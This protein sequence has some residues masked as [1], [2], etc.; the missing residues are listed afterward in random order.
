MFDLICSIAV[1]CS[2]L[3]V[4]VG[5]NATIPCG[6]ALQSAVDWWYQRTATDGTRQI[7]IGGEIVV[8]LRSR[9]R[10]GSSKPGDYDLVIEG[11]RN[12]DAGM[13]TCVEDAGLGKRHVMSLEVIDDGLHLNDLQKDLKTKGTCYTYFLNAMNLR[14]CGDLG[15]PGGASCCYCLSVYPRWACQNLP[16]FFH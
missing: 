15:Q 5:Q 3:T 16:T 2:S 13:Y 6:T 9:F 4:S 1:D 14:K 8:E 12:E 7:C 11:A 10:I